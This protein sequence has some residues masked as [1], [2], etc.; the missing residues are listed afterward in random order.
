MNYQEVKLVIAGR[1]YPVNITSEQET[2]LKEAVNRINEKLLTIE[3]KHS[4]K[5]KQD[6]LAI[7]ALQL[8]VTKRRKRFAEGLKTQDKNLENNQQIRDTVDALISK[9]DFHLKVD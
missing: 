3:A 5:D 2:N 4:I 9:I 1:V 8:M 6:S 7:L